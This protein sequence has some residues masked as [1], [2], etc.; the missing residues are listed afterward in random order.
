MISYF[1]KFLL[2]T[3]FMWRIWRWPASKAETCYRLCSIHSNKFSKYNI[4]AYKCTDVPKKWDI[5][6]Q[7]FICGGRIMFFHPHWVHISVCS[8]Q[9]PYLL[10]NTYSPRSVKWPQRESPFSTIEYRGL[11]MILPCFRTALLWVTTQRVVVSLPT[12]RDNLSVPSSGIK[13][14]KTKAG[15]PSWEII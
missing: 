13:N 11:I 9:A 3:I 14:P 8:Y 4:F 10:S 15:N 12:F 1:F 7:G 2:A 6:R 5:I